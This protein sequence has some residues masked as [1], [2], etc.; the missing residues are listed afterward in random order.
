MAVEDLRSALISNGG[1]TE[2]GEAFYPD[3]VAATDGT[4]FGETG[5]LMLLFCPPLMAIAFLAVP[6]IIFR[7]QDEEQLQ[8]K[9]TK[10]AKYSLWT[11][12]VLVDGPLG[13]V[14][15]C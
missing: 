15:C 8:Q 13:V 6:Y 10:K 1:A 11:F 14:F 3:W 12:P 7:G 2:F 4:L 5:S 9:E